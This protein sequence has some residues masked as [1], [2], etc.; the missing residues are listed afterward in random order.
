MSDTFDRARA[1]EENLGRQIEAI[2]ASDVKIT[3]L[4][5]TCTAMIGVVAA[6]LRGADLGALPTAYVLLSTLPIVTAYAFMAMSVIP[7]LRGRRSDSLVFFGGIAALD[8]A[9]FRA[10]ALALTPEAYLADLAEQ[11]HAA[12]GIARTKYRHG[13][14]A[15]LAFSSPCPSGRWRSTCSATRADGTGA[16]GG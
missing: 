14:H 3:L 16:P 2:R 8:A 15:Y 7:R 1:L 11:C 13:R 9:E 4:V 10:R 12:A 5:P 6:L